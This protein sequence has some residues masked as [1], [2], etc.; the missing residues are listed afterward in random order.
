MKKAFTFAFLFI[1]FAASTQVRSKNDMETTAFIGYSSF[2]YNDELA[3]DSGS[4]ES[5][6]FGLLGDYY[7]NEIW[8]F[9]TGFT[10][11][12]MGGSDLNYGTDFP[13]D[14]QEKLGY[15][16]IPLNANWHV[17]RKRNLNLNF[18]FTPSFLVDTKGTYPATGLNSVDLR[19]LEIVHRFQIGAS[20]GVGYKI[21]VSEYISLLADYQMFVGLTN[22]S[23]KNDTT[24]MNTGYNFNLGCVFGM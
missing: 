21:P 16:N 3:R 2:W 17:C 7:F 23:K 1:C 20:A 19:E 9:R 10:Y 12:K 22:T 4:I 24:L 8:S 5:V 14:G 6:N 15:I 11:Q 13:A 18:G